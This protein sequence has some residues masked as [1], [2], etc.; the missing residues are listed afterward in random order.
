MDYY[1]L[2]IFIV[3]LAFIFIELFF[4]VYQET[5]GIYPTHQG[6]SPT[7]PYWNGYT[8]FPFWNTPLGTTKNMSYDLRGDPLVIPRQTFPWNNS[9]IYPIYNNG[10]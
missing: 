2:T 5:F 4:T 10:V 8:N 3:C 9:S 7:N 6:Y 1:F